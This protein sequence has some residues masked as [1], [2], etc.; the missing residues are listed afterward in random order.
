MVSHTQTGGGE[1][2]KRI[3]EY[4]RLLISYSCYY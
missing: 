3:S 1:G 2:G 4:E